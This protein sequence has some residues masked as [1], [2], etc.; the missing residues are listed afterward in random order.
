MY[1]FDVDY[2]DEERGIKEIP[3]DDGDFVLAEDALK[4]QAKVDKYREQDVTADFNYR[5]E[6]EELKAKVE[7]LTAE[8]KQ[9][10]TSL[11]IA[12]S[13]QGAN[14]FKLTLKEM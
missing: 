1:R 8:N 5:L 11:R 13:A 12:L 3:C 14:G 7:E 10:N 9:L 2:L 4:L 6:H